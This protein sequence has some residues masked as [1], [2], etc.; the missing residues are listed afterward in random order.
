[1][2][3]LYKEEID[4]KET[5]TRV[6]QSPGPAPG[7]NHDDFEDPEFWEDVWELGSK[8]LPAD[9]NEGD[10]EEPAPMLVCWEHPEPQFFY[11]GYY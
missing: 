10:Q 3:E 5:N 6:L 8:D 2:F 4:K 9:Q 7:N 11:L 1:M